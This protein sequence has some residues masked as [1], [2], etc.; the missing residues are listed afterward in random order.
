MATSSVL[1][2]TNIATCTTGAIEL[3]WYF[4]GTS[5]FEVYVNDVLTATGATTSFPT[6][7]LGV[8]ITQQSGD[9]TAAAM[10]VDYIF[11]AKE[12]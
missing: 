7:E 11:A 12:R 2:I 3:G 5:T 6:T 10:N 4:D 8:A 1:Q 9:G